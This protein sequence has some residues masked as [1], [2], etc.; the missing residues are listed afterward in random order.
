MINCRG[1]IIEF[2]RPIIMGILNM[3]PDSFYDGGKYQSTEK[4]LKKAESLLSDG[5]DIIDIGAVSTRPQADEVSPEEELE[6]LLPVLKSIRKYFPDSILSVDTFRG[7]I[8]KAA[9]DEGADIIN[10]VYAGQYD[11]TMIPVISEYKAPYIIMHMQGTPATMQKDPQ[12]EHVVKS[13]LFFLSERIAVLK[14]AGI[15]DI[16]ID[17]G[18]GF[19][20]TQRHNFEILAKLEYFTTLDFPVLVGLSRKSMIYKSLDIHP[21]DALNGTTVLNTIA[22]EKG[23]A[24][25]RVHDVKEANELVKLHALYRESL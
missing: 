25:L 14:Q 17:P 4:A 23:A 10:D 15:A 13:I 16:I 8:A 18:F 3:T 19:G 5:A 12:Y 6:R 22:L 20:K 9:L 11:H 7:S 21:Q 24:I 2:E 1:K